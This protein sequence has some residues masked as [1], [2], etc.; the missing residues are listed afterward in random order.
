VLV[1]DVRETHDLDAR[2]LERRD[3]RRMLA[4]EALRV[5]VGSEERALFELVRRNVEK[6]LE[7]A[8]LRRVVDEDADGQASYS[9]KG[10]I[11][12]VM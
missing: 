1:D 7:G 2:A 4:G 8:G 6:A 9:L 11:E 12:G 5:G 10:S 3:K